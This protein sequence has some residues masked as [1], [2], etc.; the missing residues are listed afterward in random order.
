MSRNLESAVTPVTS[1]TDGT[2]SLRNG[3]HLLG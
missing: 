2:P 3:Q 1:V